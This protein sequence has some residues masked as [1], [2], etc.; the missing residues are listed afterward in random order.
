MALAAI[1]SVVAL[2]KKQWY[3]AQVT[4]T[5]DDQLTE[6]SKAIQAC[7]TMC[8]SAGDERLAFIIATDQEGLRGGSTAKA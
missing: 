8:L 3:K 6:V 5:S 7:V 1:L 4:L 2:A